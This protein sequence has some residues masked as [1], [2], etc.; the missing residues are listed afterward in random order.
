ML[1]PARTRKLLN[2]AVVASCGRSSGLTIYAPGNFRPQQA[3]STDALYLGLNFVRET[4]WGNFLRKVYPRLE[5][6]VRTV[7]Q[8]PI[9]SPVSALDRYSA[10][11]F[12]AAA[13]SQ[14]NESWV[15]LMRSKMLAP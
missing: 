3:G 15:D 1:R 10:R 8:L 6:P 13:L 11:H 7:E 12:F 4:E 9:P 14:A 2:Q 5:K